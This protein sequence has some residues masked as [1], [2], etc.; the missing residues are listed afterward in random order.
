MKRNYF[1]YLLSVVALAMLA[2]CGAAGE[3]SKLSSTSL[4]GTWRI[5]SINGVNVPAGNSIDFNSGNNTFSCKTNCNT[6]NGRYTVDDLNI[7]LEPGMMTR[8]ACLDPTIENSLMDVLP[9][10]VRMKLQPDGTVA[11]YNS[12]DEVILTLT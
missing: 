2:A 8:M 12:S 11:F 4:E 7:R 1:L 5:V 3:S 9:K 10:I 6:I